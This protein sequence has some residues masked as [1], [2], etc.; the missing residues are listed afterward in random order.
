MIWNLTLSCRRIVACVVSFYF[1]CNI[2]NYV[3]LTENS[4][5]KFWSGFGDGV[6]Y[7]KTTFL[8]FLYY[9]LLTDM[10]N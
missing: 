10:Y 2:I 8:Y 3:N 4:V 6:L 9:P 5:V 1:W 7:S